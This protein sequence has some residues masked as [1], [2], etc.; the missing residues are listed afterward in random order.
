MGV[1]A[2]DVGLL[3][4]ICLNVLRFDKVDYHHKHIQP[5]DTM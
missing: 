5:Y 1:G 4:N 3:W 2:V